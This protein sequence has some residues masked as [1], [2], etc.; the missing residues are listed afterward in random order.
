MSKKFT[1]PIDTT[2]DKMLDFLR[3]IRAL[4]LEHVAAIIAAG[5][6]SEFEVWSEIAYPLAKQKAVESL[7]A[8]EAFFA[9]LEKAQADST[10]I[11][12]P[13]RDD[14]ENKWPAED[15]LIN[16]GS[17]C[18][19]AGFLVGLAVGMQ[20]GPHAFDGIEQKRGAR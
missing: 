11:A 16:Y 19:E 14:P 18:I 4:Q 3:Q 2:N 13:L 8:L 1:A 20:L 15:V 10:R 5:V 17:D 12:F 9:R 7:T 6:F